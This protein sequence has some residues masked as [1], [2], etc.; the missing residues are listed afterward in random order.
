MERGTE[1]KDEIFPE[2]KKSNFS[3]GRLISSFKACLPFDQ[4]WS[5]TPGRIKTRSLDIDINGVSINSRG[6][7]ALFQ[8]DKEA[9]KEAMGPFFQVVISLTPDMTDVNV[10]LNGM[11]SSRVCSFLIHG[12]LDAHVSSEGE[13]DGHR[14]GITILGRCHI[15]KVPS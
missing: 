13:W 8:D 12:R 7:A 6:V 14:A 5:R 1:L 15:K 10:N 9:P 11:L 3:L 4:A 2:M